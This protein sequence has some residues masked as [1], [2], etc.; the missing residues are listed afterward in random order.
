MKIAL[1]CSLVG[2]LCGPPDD[3]CAFTHSG[4]ADLTRYREAWCC[5]F[6][7][8]DAAMFNKYCPELRAARAASA[9]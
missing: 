8:E 6:S 3:P 5:A 7:G 2:Y 4:R 1:V 9:R